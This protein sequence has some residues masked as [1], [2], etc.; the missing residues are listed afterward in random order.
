MFP[1]ITRPNTNSF[2]SHIAGVSPPLHEI[3]LVSPT[4]HEIV[5]LSPTSHDIGN[6]TSTSHHVTYIEIARCQVKRI[7]LLG[8]WEILPLHKNYK[9]VIQRT[10][11]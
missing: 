6:M 5:L 9:Q 4:L 7:I 3:V 2:E 10:Q 11:P 1:V 8:G